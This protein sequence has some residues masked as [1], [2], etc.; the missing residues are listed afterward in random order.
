MR[1][2]VRTPV[3]RRLAAGMLGALMTLGV[4]GV[5][6]AHEHDGSNAHQSNNPA[7]AHREDRGGRFS[8][9]HPG[10]ER[11]WREEHSGGADDDCPY[12][13]CE[14]NDCTNHVDNCES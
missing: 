1:P 11:S 7:A 12:H 8:R 2:L 10:D 5:A 9:E 4:P 6:L 14:F 3:A 13:A